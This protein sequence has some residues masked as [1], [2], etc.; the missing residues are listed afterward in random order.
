MDITLGQTVELDLN[1]QD[2]RPIL[3]VFQLIFDLNNSRKKIKVVMLD[4]LRID[5]QF[6]TE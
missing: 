5:K 1:V 6:M 2:F 4:D 3:N